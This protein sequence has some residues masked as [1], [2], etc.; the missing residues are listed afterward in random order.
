MKTGDLVTFCG[1]QDG[2][3][4]FPAE[5]TGIVETVGPV[6]CAVRYA[7]GIHY[8]KVTDLRVVEPR[9]EQVAA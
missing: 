5:E 9:A 8:L 3:R 2:P 1:L 7:W 4:Y 6:R